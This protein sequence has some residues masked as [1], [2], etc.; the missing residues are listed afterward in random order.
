MICLSAAKK[1]HRVKS[2]V[3]QQVLYNHKPALW[4]ARFIVRLGLAFQA[5][6][7]GTI[8]MDEQ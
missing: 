2:R 4:T 6:H 1:N 8:R 5:A 3:Y 7:Y